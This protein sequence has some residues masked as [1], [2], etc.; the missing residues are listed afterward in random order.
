MPHGTYGCN[1]GKSPPFKLCSKARIK[2]TMPG[3]Y[4]VLL[5]SLLRLS[6]A[7]P[8]E[9]EFDTSAG[10]NFP[11]RHLQQ[12]AYSV[13]PR[14]GHRGEEPVTT[15]DLS[16][17]STPF[18]AHPDR[19]L[20]TGKAKRYAV[21]NDGKVKG[22]SKR[23][24]IFVQA[25][26]IQFNP[27]GTKW[28]ELKV[29]VLGS[30]G[31]INRRY[32]GGVAASLILAES[33]ATPVRS[34]VATLEDENG[35]T[36]ER[37]VSIASSVATN[38]VAVLHFSPPTD[39][40]YRFN[41]TC[42]GCNQKL[43]T[44]KQY[45]SAGTNAVLKVTSQ[46][47][48][49]SSGA[50]L[51]Y[52]PAVQLEDR[53]GRPLEVKTT[54]VANIIPVGPHTKEEVPLDTWTLET[55]EFGYA[56]A[57]GIRVT[58]AGQHIIQFVTTLWQD[59]RLEVS[60][61]SFEVVPGPAAAATF[62][63]NPPLRV[64][65][66]EPFSIVAVLVDSYGN[67]T[68]SP[69]ELQRNG[70]PVEVHLGAFNKAGQRVPLHGH[71]RQVTC[72]LCPKGAPSSSAEIHVASA[73]RVH[74]HHMPLLI[75][76]RIPVD[77]EG[78]VPSR[79]YWGQLR[80][81]LTAEDWSFGA[82]QKPVSVEVKEIVLLDP[83]RGLTGDDG[84]KYLRVEPKRLLF[85]V[86]NAAYPQI[87]YVLPWSPGVVVGSEGL[88]KPMSATHIGAF[89]IELDVV[90][91][92]PS[93][94]STA[95]VF[96]LPSPALARGVSVSFVP[97]PRDLIV[98]AKDSD[99]NEVLTGF[100]QQQLV[101]EGDVIAYT[102][103]LSACPLENEEVEVRI[104]GDPSGGYFVEPERLHFSATNWQQEQTVSIKVDQDD[105]AP[106]GDEL[107]FEGS[108]IGNAI[109][110]LILHH[111]VSSSEEDHAWFMRGGKEVAFSVWDDDIAGVDWRA[112]SDSL[113]Q[114]EH[115]KLGFRLR[116]QPV[117]DVSLQLHCE[118]TEIIAQLKPDQAFK[119]A[120]SSLSLIEGAELGKITVQP[121]NW[122][123][124]YEFLLRLKIT[125]ESSAAQSTR[126]DDPNYNTSERTTHEFGVSSTFSVNLTFKSLAF[127]LKGTANRGVECLP[128]P[129]GYEC[130]DPMEPP[131]PC[132][133][134]HMSLGGFLACVPC[135]EG[136]TCP[137]G[138]AVP[139]KLRPG[140]YHGISVEGYVS[141]KGASECIP[142]P[143]GF[144]CKTGRASDLEVNYHGL[145]LI[146][147]RTLGHRFACTV[148][149]G[150][151]FRSFGGEPTA[152]GLSGSG[153]E[154]NF[155]AE[156][157]DLR[158]DFTFVEQNIA[159]LL[160]PC[161]VGYF[162]GDGEADCIP[163]GGAVACPTPFTREHCFV[164]F[165]VALPDDP[166]ECVP[167][168]AGHSCS[169]GIVERCPDFHYARLGE[170]VCRLCKGGYLCK[171]GATAPDEG[172]LVPIGYYRSERDAQVHPCPSGTLGLIPGATS[173]QNC[174]P[175]PSG[176]MCEM[177]DEGG[178]FL[179]SS[180][181]ACPPGYVCLPDPF[182]CPWMEEL[183][184]CH[185]GT[186]L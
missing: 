85:P 150:G 114:S 18:S 160:L 186:L 162:S 93:W 10:E 55:D 175:C 16:S 96:D 74:V 113:V 1:G 98:Y 110:T 4:F 20:N 171:G 156:D 38:G 105:I 173:K 127:L 43:N 184:L 73:S 64:L 81:S 132:P 107:S 149:Q 102:L 33:D 99:T 130:P 154:T 32:D 108:T 5:G 152:V 145:T 72:T 135:P 25:R 95:V 109:R 27:G 181:V 39:G 42:G 115:F 161:K 174:S 12:S 176:Y 168:P 26:Q 54:I 86:E 61:A 83:L 119:D 138:T 13:Q 143:A 136:F 118:G 51:E 80:I 170:G 147:N 164:P 62:S 37:A 82:P 122:R 163:C 30:D 133:Q 31:K 131:K 129:P 153:V 90:S 57:S 70:D 126:S 144:K 84:G 104:H 151:L 9:L 3:F 79:E 182:A 6:C 120:S 117:A 66:R 92:D 166:T 159:D 140:F 111:E 75:E 148:Q 49:A 169:N 155:H 91:E 157:G 101:R 24:E 67:E 22:D 106:S 52:Q 88:S 46:P 34:L 124:E 23:P 178:E 180:A 139:K 63:I 7:T 179:R 71:T 35:V 47:S 19:E 45:F 141:N 125:A 146:L 142:C 65:I 103:R 68:A 116:S 165:A 137:E 89:S 167:C 121:A 172:D 40:V 29:E 69:P 56:K 28:V 53:D 44:E 134:E 2:Y 112:N 8:A 48:G 17:T 50:I 59:T 100:P 11:S 128:C 123:T 58:K 87:F 76:R 15:A 78:V 36:A 185:V 97:G 14:V 60:S 41:I 77:G 183:D 21:E 177:K 94:S 158:S